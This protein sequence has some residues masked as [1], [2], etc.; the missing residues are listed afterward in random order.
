[1]VTVLPLT[2]TED[3][4]PTD[5]NEQAQ[6]ITALQSA[7][8]PIS[9]LWIFSH[10]W[11]NSRDDALHLY[12][13]ECIPRM[14][15]AIAILQP[16][17][18]NPLY[19]GVI[20][21][22]KGWADFFNQP[23]PTA[24]SSA[25]SPPGEVSSPVARVPISKADFLNAYAAFP[26]W[27]NESQEMYMS[28]LGELYDYMSIQEP[29]DDD[30]GAFFKILQG[31]AVEDPRPESLTRSMASIQPTEAVAWIRNYHSVAQQSGSQQMRVEAIAAN[32]NNASTDV[33]NW[34]D[35]FLNVFRVFTF[36]QMKN[37][38]GVVGAN[39]LYAFLVTIK[40]QF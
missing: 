20:W 18:Y 36:W 12:N 37:R 38:A 6:I 22:S 17:Q 5:P 21:P 15:D 16:E 31:M 14:Q 40:Q 26:L 10:G 32:Q 1:M 19:V 9:D 2:F 39:G 13:D 28:Q 23:Q 35:S 25:A 24:N 11:N 33:S 29:T 3:G 8:P 34:F 4:L 7:Q 27:Q 30:I